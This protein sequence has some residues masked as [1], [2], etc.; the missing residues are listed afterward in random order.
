MKGKWSGKL[1]SEAYLQRFGTYTNNR[2]GE[3]E[4][5]FISFIVPPHSFSLLPFFTSEE[6]K[7]G[8]KKRNKD[9]RN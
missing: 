4:I 8:C 5:V 2:I 1:L 9:R 6:M 3:T 7:K